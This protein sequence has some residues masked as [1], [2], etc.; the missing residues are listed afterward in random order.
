M[1]VGQAATAAG[2][3][4][5]VAQHVG[6]HVEVR[7]HPVPQRADRADARG[8]ASD[9]PARVLADRVDPARYLVD[10]DDGRLEHGNS[11]AANEDECVRRA[12]IDRE[13]ATPLEM[14]LC[15]R[16]GFTLPG[17]LPGR[18]RYPTPFLWLDVADRL[19][20]FPT[21]AGKVLEHA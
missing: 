19:G 10:R 5:E 6:R 2:S 9:H 17:A 16:P 12:E 15:H 21:M 8:C 13:L 1:G 14:P 11:L 18:D 4:D 3:P 7:D 20:Q